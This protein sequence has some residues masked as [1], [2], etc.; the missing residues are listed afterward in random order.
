M[1]VFW[2]M[3]CN[4]CF[5]SSAHVTRRGLGK[6]LQAIA[7]VW[8]LIKQGPAG[9][10]VAARVLIVTQSGLVHNWVREISKW[11]TDS[12]LK[13]L[14]TKLASSKSAPEAKTGTTED[15]LRT[16]KLSSAHPVLILSYEQCRAFSEQL[17]ELEIDLAI[18]DEVC[19]LF[20][21]L[22]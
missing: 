7:L 11:L 2:P 20:A 18:C 1:A 3:R 19:Y 6:T 15:V 22:C 5:G 8:T 21:S 16:F 10:P 9:L 4:M 12:R 14:W 13:P 17:L